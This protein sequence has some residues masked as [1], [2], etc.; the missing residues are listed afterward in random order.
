MNQ[1]INIKNIL[2]LFLTASIIGCKSKPAKPN[3]LIKSKSVDTVQ[4][5]STK[6]RVY[7]VDTHSTVVYEFKSDSITQRAFIRYL[8]DSIILFKLVN[9]DKNGQTICELSDTA[10]SLK[11]I[12]SY[13]MYEDEKTEGDAWGAKEYFYYKNGYKNGYTLD[14]GIDVTGKKRMLVEDPDSSKATSK[15]CNFNSFGT[16]WKIAN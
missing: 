3:A 14:I 5:H 9:I 6:N 15:N 2:A 12:G 7:K 11:D 13:A 16:L 1:T 8:A 10:K 4:S